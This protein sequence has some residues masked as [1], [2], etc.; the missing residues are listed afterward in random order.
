MAELDA[1]TIAA[2]KAEASQ[3]R[4]D[5]DA[6]RRTQAHEQRIKEQRT[7]G[8]QA[9]AT[10]KASTARDVQVIQARTASRT[11]EREAAAAIK[12]QTSAQNR[13]VQREEARAQQ[14]SRS[15]QLAAT[16]GR[17]AVS[18]ATPSGDSNLVMV[19][20]FVMAGLIVFYK[21]VTQADTTSGWLSSLSDM[22]HTVSS[23]TP[24]FTSVSKG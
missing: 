10:K 4:K 7:R 14:P 17:Q 18:T 13:A 2:V 20:I 1:A 11:Q 9:R 23:N 6:A 5:A 15:Q 8:R 22:L 24:L 3:R 19:T 12:L 21:I 16:A